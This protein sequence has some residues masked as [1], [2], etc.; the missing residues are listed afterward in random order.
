MDWF[1]KETI[2]NDILEAMWLVKETMFNNVEALEIAIDTG[3][4]KL[5][6]KIDSNV[7]CQAFEQGNIP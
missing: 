7:A 5:C 4:N 6:I 1:T 3:W 2:I